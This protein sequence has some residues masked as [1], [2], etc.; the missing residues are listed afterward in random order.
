MTYSNASLRLGLPIG[1]NQRVLKWLRLSVSAQAEEEEAVLA[2]AEEAVAAL[3]PVCRVLL[4]HLEE[5]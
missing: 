2:Q 1:R 3:W 4:I 5:L